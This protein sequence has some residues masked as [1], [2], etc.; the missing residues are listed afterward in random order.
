[1]VKYFEKLLLQ[2]KKMEIEEIHMNI[3]RWAGMK[4]VL[5]FFYTRDTIV[6]DYLF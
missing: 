2:N 5:D 1:M 4:N 6:S 3:S